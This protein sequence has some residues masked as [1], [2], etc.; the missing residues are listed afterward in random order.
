MWKGFG[1]KAGSG[2]GSGEANTASNVGTGQGLFKQKVGVNLEFNNI[3][4]ENALL[5]VATD[6]VTNDIELTVNEASIDHNNLTNTHNLTT[7]ID[8][9]SLTNTHNLT[10]DIEHD[11]LTNFVVNEHIDHS[12]VSIGTAATSGLSCGGDITTSRNLVVDPTL[13]TEKASAGVDAR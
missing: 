3:K 6:G 12:G 4:S 1:D 7:D 10:T 8:H 5:T 11:A 13:A 9:N 2:N